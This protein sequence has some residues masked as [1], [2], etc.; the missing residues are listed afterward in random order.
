M[1]YRPALSRTCFPLDNVQSLSKRQYALVMTT[2]VKFYLDV[3][4]H[5]WRGPLRVADRLCSSD[6]EIVGRVVTLPVADCSPIRH[7]HK[8]NWEL[9]YDLMAVARNSVFS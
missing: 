2:T 1:I 6:P 7:P 4:L 9:P 8:Q 5:S 3:N